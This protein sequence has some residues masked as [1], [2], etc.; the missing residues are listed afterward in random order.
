MSEKDEVLDLGCGIGLTSL[1]IVKETSAKVY[2][3]DLW[4]RAEDNA[5]RFGQWGI[6][7]Q[8]IPVCEDANELNFSHWIFSELVVTG[9]DPVGNYYVLLKK[10]STPAKFLKAKLGTDIDRCTGCGFYAEICPMNSIDDKDYSVSGICIKCHVCIR[11][12]PV[13]AKSFADE[14]FLSHVKMLEENYAGGQRIF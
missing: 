6:G 14:Q 3:N 9:N 5:K 4:I 1:I 11:N 8:I 7:E 2:A 12:C 10:D 13:Y